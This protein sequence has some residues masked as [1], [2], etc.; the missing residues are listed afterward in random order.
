MPWLKL[1]N[2]TNIGAHHQLGFQDEVFEKIIC[3]ESGSFFTRSCFYTKTYIFA[4][5]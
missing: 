4:P 3:C 2:I 5:L 1:S